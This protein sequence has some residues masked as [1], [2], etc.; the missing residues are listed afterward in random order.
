MAAETLPRFGR[1]PFFAHLWLFWRLRLWTGANRFRT[2]SG[3]APVILGALALFGATSA[4]GYGV[5]ALLA[6]PVIAASIRWSTFL[7][8]LVTFLTSAVFVIW[9]ILSAGVDEHS[10]LSRF[11][12][13]PIKPFRLFVASSLAAI[14]EPRSLAFYPAIVGAVWGYWEQRPFPILHGALLTAMFCVLN[15]AWSRAWL[16]LVLNVLRHRRSAEI[17]G[18]GFLAALFLAALAPPI[19]ARWVYDLFK[20]QNLTFATG[21]V[22]DDA[23]VLNA[24][25]ALSRL[26]TGT[27][28]LSIEHLARG[29]TSEALAYGLVHM[30]FWAL[31]GFAAAYVLLVRFYKNTARPSK[32]EAA[33]AA[34][35]GLARDGALYAMLDREASDWVRNP[36]TRLLCAVPFFLCIL[37][38]LVRARDLVAA[39]TGG[40]ADAWLLGVL[41]AYGGLVVGANFAQNA[42]AYDGAGLA[43]LYAA[44]VPLRTVFI[45]KN[46]VHAAGA[47]TVGLLLTAFYGLYVHAY[48]ASSALI[49]VLAL[50]GQMPILLAAGNVLSVIA[51]RKFHASLRRRDRPPALATFGGLIA[52]AVAVTPM[53]YVLRALGNEEPGVGCIA[54]LL[55]LAAAG[56]AIYLLTLPRAC[57]LLEARREKVLRAVMR[58]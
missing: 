41:C 6:H 11:A 8:R 15:V 14:V 43:L 23:I 47:L 58:E 27:L 13:F 46:A 7:L 54:A 19:D 29:Y 24:S 52:A 31:V 12:T 55:G 5:H 28:S 9:P 36:K 18:V 33:Q 45:A 22:I 40:A 4:L 17:L 37:L 20:S 25:E 3:A 16:T 38:H 51:P 56:W 49:G 48:Q 32:K 53:G 21:G 30:G 42:F 1:V 34:P 35:K 50:L 2:A 39:A 26:P 57:A 10:E 44:P